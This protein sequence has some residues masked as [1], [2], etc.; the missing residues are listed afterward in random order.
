ME[1]SIYSRLVEQLNDGRR[2][3]SCQVCPY[4]RMAPHTSFRIG[5]KADLMLVP[6]NPDALSFILSYLT[7]AKIP[8]RVVGNLTNCL[9]DDGGYAGV[10]IRTTRL[11]DVRVEGHVVE[12]EAGATLARVSQVAMEAELGGFESLSGIPGSVGGALAMN[13]GAYGRSISDVLVSAVVYDVQKGSFQEMTGQA[14]HFAYRSSDIDDHRFVAVSA[15]FGL[16]PRPRGEI[17]M[18]IR[19]LTEQRR[20]TQPLEFP[21]AGSVFKRPPNDYAG[22]L[23][24]AAGLK[25]MRIGDAEV[26]VKHAG[27]IVNRGHATAK[28][29]RALI[30]LVQERVREESDVLLSPEIE[31]IS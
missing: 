15:R 24:E 16:T 25:G 30:S 23:I 10:F 31:I 3:T 20:A 12:A 17:A 2:E 21:S 8:Y 5:G 26:S 4:E 29:V 9:V 19:Q 27:F 13:A 28:D 11:R 6:D 22:R 14:L 7:S 18:E 1:Q